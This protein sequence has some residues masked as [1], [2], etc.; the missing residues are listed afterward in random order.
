L[1]LGT[2]SKSVSKVQEGV[3]IGQQGDRT[4][5]NP[6]AVWRAVAIPL[7]GRKPWLAAALRPEDVR[8]NKALERRTVHFDAIR[9][10]ALS[11]KLSSLRRLEGIGASIGHIDILILKVERWVWVTDTSVGNVTAGPL[12]HLIHDSGPCCG[13]GS[14]SCDRDCGPHNG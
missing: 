8:V 7:L 10:R 2:K 1:P 6:S 11:A 14:E 12:V 13:A 5:Y 3:D 4:T 9:T